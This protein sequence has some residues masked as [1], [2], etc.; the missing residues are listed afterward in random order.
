MSV[1]TLVIA[2]ISIGSLYALVALGLVLIYR[3]QGIVNFAHGEALMIGAF[4]GYTSLEVVRLPY[5]V[6]F[7]VAVVLGGVLGALVERL[8]FRRI[9]HRSHTTLAMV[10]VGVSVLLKGAARLPFGKDVYTLPPVLA[11]QGALQIGPAMVAPQNAVATVVALLLTAALF[12]FFRLTRLGKQMRATQQN[13]TGARL[14]GVDTN[15]VYATT[16]ILAAALG[17]AAGVLAGPITLLYP[18]MGT[19]FLL[20]GF[21]AAVLGGFDS[22]VGAVIGGFIVGVI[23]MLF[24]GYLSTAFQEVSAFLIILVVLFVK[25]HGLFGKPPVNRV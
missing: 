19:A 5:P 9:A 14:V 22:V 4:A 7:A 2:G 13:V 18:D 3:T 11:D 17:A 10:A 25:P 6:A 12:L 23:E 15:R 21:A 16:W 1:F 20:K 8:A 24:G